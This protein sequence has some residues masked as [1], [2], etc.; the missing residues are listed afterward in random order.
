M[1][2][3]YL[4]EHTL[5]SIATGSGFRCRHRSVCSSRSRFCDEALAKRCRFVYTVIC[6]N[7]C[8]DLRNNCLVKRTMMTN[9]TGRPEELTVHLSDGR[10]LQ[11]LSIG[12]SDGSP[13]FH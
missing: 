9:T 6:N 11:V 12:K 2:S 4:M 7:C 10:R 5:S 8:N 13:I 1:K 3:K